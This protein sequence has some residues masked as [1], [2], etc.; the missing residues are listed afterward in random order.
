MRLALM[1]I[2]IFVLVVIVAA[3]KL[4]AQDPVKVAPKNFK[5]LLENDHVRVLD[6][7]SKSGEKIP[8]HSH[9][10]YVAYSITGSGK[11]TF[12]FPDGKTTVVPAGAGQ[13]TW[14]D[15]ETHATEYTGRGETHVVL[16]EL[17]SQASGKP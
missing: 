15:A 14:R 13:T 12:S 1:R 16:V 7:H 9:P 17:K 3:G 10:G 5:V 4:W 11:T 2:P 8:M 6:F